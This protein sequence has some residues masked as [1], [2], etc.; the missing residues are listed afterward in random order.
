M[1]R[2]VVPDNTSVDSRDWHESLSEPGW[3]WKGNTSSDEVVGHMLAYPLVHDLLDDDEGAKEN[4]QNLM[5]TIMGRCHEFLL[6]LCSS[7]PKL[8]HY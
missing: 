5:D 4:I 8:L 2:S 3:R 7:Q 6:Y 1:A